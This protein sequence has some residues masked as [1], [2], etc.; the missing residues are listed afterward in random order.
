MGFGLTMPLVIHPK[1]MQFGLWIPI[2]PLIL[3][4]IVKFTN[5]AML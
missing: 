5:M 2:N 1:S 3:L 4:L